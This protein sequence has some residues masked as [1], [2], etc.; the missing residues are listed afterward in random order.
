MQGFLAAGHA[1]AVTGVRR[2]GRHSAAAI[3]CPVVVTGFEPVDLL[4]GI[5]RCVRQLE[6]GRAELENAYARAVRPAGNIPALAM[7]RSVFEVIDREWRGLGILPASGLG[8]RAEYAD[9]DAA[10]RFDL[11]PPPIGG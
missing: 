6:D 7:I 10:L 11:G 3:T 4:D 1:A 9:F 8:L 2:I 5:L